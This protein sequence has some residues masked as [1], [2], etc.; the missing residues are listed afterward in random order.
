[1][2]AV[3]LT[4]KGKNHLPRAINISYAKITYADRGDG[5]APTSADVLQLFSLPAGATVLRT[6]YIMVTAW[7]SSSTAVISLGDGGSTTRY[8]SSADIKG[9]TANVPVVGTVKYRYAAADTVDA[10][11]TLGASDCTTGDVRVGI[12][13]VNPDAILPYA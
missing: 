10:I 13:W 6:W 12:E 4:E 7:N 9:G 8:H 3:N 5:T 11:I 2:A 1:M